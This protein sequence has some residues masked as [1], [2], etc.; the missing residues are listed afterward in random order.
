MSKKTELPSALTQ[1]DNR[2][3]APGIMQE[4]I[5]RPWYTTLKR[6]GSRHL[7]LIP[8]S[9]LMASSFFYKLI[10]KFVQS[11]NLNLFIHYTITYPRISYKYIIVAPST[12][13]Y[14]LGGK[15]MWAGPTLKKSPPFRVGYLA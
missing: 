1:P 11:M 13:I 8:C 12:Q 14:N 6:Q 3:S 4:S 5:G 10:R 7:C 9:T 15:S 2:I